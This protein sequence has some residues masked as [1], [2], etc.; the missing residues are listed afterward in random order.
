MYLVSSKH[1]SLVALY[2]LPSLTFRLPVLVQAAFPNQ[3]RALILNN[4][5]QDE[6]C[7][8]TK[9]CKNRMTFVCGFFPKFNLFLTM[10]ATQC[11]QHT[12][13]IYDRKNNNNNKIVVV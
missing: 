5:N 13:Q 2:I 9:D 7:H 8:G 10:N 11:K 6:R 4:E 3:V 1:D 12:L